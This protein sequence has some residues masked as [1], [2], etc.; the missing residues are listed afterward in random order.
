MIKVDL[1]CH[2]T[3][4]RHPSEWFLQRL[5]TQES[6]TEVEAL[7]RLA[8]DR[9][10]A[11]VTITDHNCIDGALALVEAHP[12]DTFVSVEITTYFPEDGCKVHVLAYGITPGQ[13]GRIQQLRENIYEL[14]DYLREQD[15]ACSVAHATYA[16]NGRLTADTLEKLI[17]LFDVFEGI[18]GA[19]AA[20]SN[21]AWV[22]LLQ[23]LTP[24]DMARLYER[25]GIEPWGPD[26]WIK[27][28][29]GGSDDHAG[30][31]IGETYTLTEDA[32]APELLQRVKARETLAAGRHG[33][34]K[35]LAF[36][37]YKI[38]YDFSRARGR[39]GVGFWHEVN[40]LL[41]D[42][43]APG[44]RDWLVVRRMRR[45][46]AGETEGAVSRLFG[47]LLE[48]RAEGALSGDEHLRR[49]YRALAAVSD[50][51]L[52]S[53][54]TSLEVD[55]QKGDA[56]RLVKSLS[57]SLPAVFLAAPFFTTMRHMH[58]DRPLVQA[59]RARFGASAEA[60]AKRLL[61]F[62][63]TVTDLN[64]VSVTMRNLARCA[65]DTGR[66]MKLV[67][68]LPEGE[69]HALPPNSINLPCI[70]SAT[71]SF[72][73]AFTLRVPSPMRSLEL[74]AREMPDEIVISTPGPVGLF[75][76]AFARLLGVRCVGVYHTDFTRQVEMFIGDPWVSSTV[77]MLTRSFFRMMDEVRVP[78]RQYMDI[79]ESR[80]IDRARMRLFQRGVE[81]SFG[82]RDAEEEAALRRRLGIPESAPVLLWAGRMGKEKNLDFLMDVAT[83][84]LSR[85]PGAWF[86]AAGDGPE[87][88]RLRAEHGSRAGVLFP[89][90]IE[91]GEL[92]HAYGMADAFVF[93][94]TTDTFGMVVLEAQ[95]CGTP[96]IVT[97]VGGPQ[98][99][100]RNGQTGYVLP[101]ADREAW[102]SALIA[103]L[104][105][106]SGSPA[107]YTAWREAIRREFRHRHGWDA[108]LDQMT[109]GPA[110]PAAGPPA[111][112][113]APS[114][115][116]PS[117]PAELVAV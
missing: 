5:G 10:M 7:Y 35:S 50:E 90:R 85:R 99:I 57:S 19:R 77:E 34:H 116:A 74:L 109:G 44:L 92:R 64:G 48:A 100:V 104:D 97:D 49:V 30:L 72:Y 103:I 15:I 114:R 25:H 58:R 56:G 66:P 108:V 59:L 78:T 115:R 94:S 13:F 84:A 93:P 71:P 23:N 63:D 2:S 65:F 70:Y 29:T 52:R 8:K 111:E 18:N 80:G 26:S 4:S 105:R 69:A 6:Y 36:A 102:V 101:A 39:D 53:I 117:A 73:S 38:A 45:M 37:I 88:E 96:A 87:L 9:G 91:R 47:E 60:P 27:G 51:F 55:L 32:T 79:L 110:R 86:V 20:F 67:T 62:S 98:E 21:H 42:R 14:R 31:M 46:T 112:S 75:G 40:S 81:P 43:G 17:L 33:D 1:H 24:N 16:V 11:Y 54:A 82:V 61:W 3:H 41:F 83:E 12:D 106:R 22:D 113:P 68:A 95:S 76:L 89:G 107:D 28:F